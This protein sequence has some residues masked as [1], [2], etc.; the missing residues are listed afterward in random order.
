MTAQELRNDD[1]E[2]FTLLNELDKLKAM[3]KAISDIPVTELTAELKQSHDRLHQRFW[4]ILGKHPELKT[5][6]EI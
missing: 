4:L 3:M 6:I 5:Q 1:M 2:R